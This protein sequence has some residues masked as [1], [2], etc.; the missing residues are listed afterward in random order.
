MLI[1]ELLHSGIQMLGGP[2]FDGT[3]FTLTAKLER[4]TSVKSPTSFHGPD[5]PEDVDAAMMG[6]RR[7]DAEDEVDPDAERVSGENLV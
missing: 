5:A 6:A 4:E 1:C 3:K 7:T 2:V